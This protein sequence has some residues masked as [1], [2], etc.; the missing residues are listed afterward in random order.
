[1]SAPDFSSDEWDLLRD[2]VR[3]VRVGRLTA[4]FLRAFLSELF[5]RRDRADLAAKV[6]AISHAEALA[7]HSRLKECE[8]QAPASA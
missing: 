3:P 5:R 1:M 6:R 8:P 2:A 7:L 4:G